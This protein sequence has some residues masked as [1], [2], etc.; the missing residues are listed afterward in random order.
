VVGRDP[1]FLGT[2]WKFPPEFSLESAGVEMVSATDDIRESLRILL[3]TSPGERVMV[4]EFGCALWR[5]V[6]EKLD[7]TTITEIQEL[8]REAILHWEPRITVD[9]VSAEADRDVA[10]LVHIDVRYTIRRTNTRSNFVYPF[11]LNE[12]TI[13]APAL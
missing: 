7:V 4:P 1:Q 9:S 11:Y 10:G 8:V 3:S 6:F 12:A 13:P 5:M 2:G